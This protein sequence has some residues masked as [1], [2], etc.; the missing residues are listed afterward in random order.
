MDTE[1]KALTILVAEENGDLKARFDPTVG[2]APPDLVA[3]H[4]RLMLDGCSECLLD[5]QAID[6]FLALCATTAKVLERKIGQRRDGSFVLEVERDLMSVYLT[7]VPPQGG[8]PAG[9]AVIDA[10]R[11]KGVVFG[12][13]HAVL[14]EA[15]AAGQ[16]KNLL[17]AEGIPDEDGTPVRFERLFVEGVQAVGAEDENANI[18]M[19]DIGRLPLV[20]PGDLL[21]RRHPAIPG[22]NGT[23]VLNE[24]VLPRACSDDPFDSDLSGA[25]PSAEDPDLLVATL[26]GQAVV[27]KRGVRVNPVIDVANVDLE[28]GSIKFEGT[29]NVAGD[30]RAG[31]KV[32]VTGDV[33]VKGCIEAAEIIAGGSV[34]VVGG[35]IGR[36][37][38]RAPG[39]HALPDN[40]ARIRCGTFLKALFAESAHIEA[41]ETITIDRE[42]NHC[43]LMAGKDV[44]IGKLGARGGQ[45]VGGVVQAK[46]RV[47]CTVLGSPATVATRV[48]V[49]LDPYLDEEILTKK[50]LLQQKSAEL[51]RVLQLQ[52]HLQRN[53]QKDK[54]GLGSKV[55]NTRAQ[56]MAAVVELNEVLAQMAEQQVTTEEACIV[57][58]KALH[59]GCELRVGRQVLQAPDDYGA[60]TVRLKEGEIT[61]ER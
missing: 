35:I 49:G 30:I 50:R 13:H 21:M 8:K 41:M 54:D 51:E 27:V 37:E 39:A 28:T 60:V 5:Q 55:E 19:T 29:L 17:I 46:E 43:E 31:M 9:P 18:K 44:L 2:L 14:D 3:L 53:P 12:I 56:L 10:L 45:L 38:A 61:I 36:S 33:V 15:L 40:T 16:C 48:Q 47:E 24:P 34:S 42:A 1:Q 26:A 22:K 58:R 20:H 4:E 52:E 6:E 32:E 7:L 25:A 23:N 11:E 59:F 57:T